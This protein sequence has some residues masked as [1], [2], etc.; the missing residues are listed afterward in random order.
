MPDKIILESPEV[1]KNPSA[2]LDP[3]SGEPGAHPIG[4]GVGAATGGAAGAAIGLGG[5]PVGVVI[6]TVVGALIGGYAGKGVAEGIDPTV[7]D[8]FWRENH[9]SQWFAAQGGSYD[10]YA[11]AYRTG[12]TGYRPGQSFEDREAELRMDYEGDPQQS[13]AQTRL[14]IVEEAAQ[15]MKSTL[16]WELARHAARA[17]YERLEREQHHKPGD[18]DPLPPNPGQIG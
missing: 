11:Q 7:E 3:L 6:G 15:Q 8:A 2:H 12:Y 4:T 1:E 17:A 9:S 10:T 5:G 14:E 13:E 18:P 16:N